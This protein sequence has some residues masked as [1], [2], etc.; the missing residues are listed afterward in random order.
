VRVFAAAFLVKN[1]TLEDYTVKFEIWDTAG[2][3]TGSCAWVLRATVA[4]SWNLECFVRIACLLRPTERYKSLVP[5]YYRDASACLVVFDVTSR[6]R[7][8]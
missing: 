5:M 7:V 2:Q 1:V 4:V 6:V 3:G 8:P